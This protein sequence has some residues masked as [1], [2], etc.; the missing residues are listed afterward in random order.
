MKKR[1]LFF[2][3]AR[4]EFGL[5]K[6]LLSEIKN[7][8]TFQLLLVASGMH[9]SPEFGLTYRD[10]EKDGFEVTEKIE[11][12]ISSDTPVGICKSIGVGLIGY[13][14]V[15]ERIKPDISVVLGDRYEALAFAI[16]NTVSRVPLAHLYGGEATY[17][18]IDEAFRHSITKMSYLHFAATESYRN[19]II[20]MGEAP[21][22]VFNVGALG[23]DNIKKSKLLTIEELEKA[24]SFKFGTRNLM[25]TFHPVTL[26][27]KTSSH[28]CRELLEVLDG[29]PETHIIFT[30]ANADTD[31]RIINTLFSEYVENHRDKSTFIINMGNLLYYSTLQFVDAVVGNSSSGIIE[32]PTFKIGTIN[33]GNRQKGRISA[34]SVINCPTDRESI[35]HALQKLY[36]HEFQEK[37]KRVHNPYGNGGSAVKIISII[38]NMEFFDI[39]NKEF[40]I[41]ESNS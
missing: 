2:T 21:E 33:I 20:Q 32:A 24:L 34:E 38:K 6:P 17:G 23:I 15:I 11:M 8:N 14:E 28:Y 36:S 39:E 18:L 29:L 37:L 13:G 30:G 7:D 3:G 5:L 25:V 12:L 26:E 40:N 9:L 35:S 31:G 19:R 1:I 10:I 27:K 4:S 16:A 22:R 41:I